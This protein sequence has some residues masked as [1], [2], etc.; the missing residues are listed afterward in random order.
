MSLSHQ[1]DNENGVEEDAFN[2]VCLLCG[3]PVRA[4]VCVCVSTLEETRQ[5][6]VATLVPF[7]LLEEVKLS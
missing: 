3:A 5:R 6:A 1:D 2:M 4:H 7:S